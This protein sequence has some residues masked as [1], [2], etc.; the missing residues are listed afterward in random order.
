MI[1]SFIQRLSNQYSFL[2]VEENRIREENCRLVTRMEKIHFRPWEQG[3]MGK[4]LKVPFP[5]SKN[6]EKL[7]YS[8]YR[9]VGSLNYAKR[10]EENERI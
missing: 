6:N 7:N 8:K 3:I 2:L 5:S 4:D 9:K 1:Q 10:K